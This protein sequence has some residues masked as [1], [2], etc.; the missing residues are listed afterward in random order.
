MNEKS[1]Y[2]T[3]AIDYA[4]SNPHIGHVYE[5][6]VADV[7]VR[8]HRLLGYKTRFSIGTDE[9]GEKIFK[10]AKAQGV[11][12]QEFVD[13]IVPE[14]FQALYKRLGISAD[15]FIRTTESGHKK[16]V[17]QMLERAQ[18]AG[19]IYLAEYEG[20]YSV[21]SERFVTE[22]ELVESPDGL[23]RLPGDKDPPELRREQ[24][25]FLRMEKYRPWLL[26]YIEA[27]PDFIQPVGYKNELLEMLREPVGDLSISRPVERLP[28]GIPIPWDEGHV[29]YVWYDALVNYLSQCYTDVPAGSSESLEHFWQ[30]TWHVIGKDIL[31]PHALFWPVMLK[32]AGYPL[33]ERLN[34]HGHI[35]AA[36]GQ[37]MGKSLGNALNPIALL[38]TYGVDAVRY[39]LT[40]DT[41]YGPDSAFGEEG[42][43]SRLNSDLA[44]DLGN[45]LSRVGSMVQKFRAGVVPA[46]AAYDPRE[47]AIIDNFAVLPNRVLTEVRDLRLHLGVEAVLESVRDLNKFVAESKPWD[48]AKDESKSQRLDTVLY[49]L[50]EGLRLISL[51][52]EPVIP[53]KALEIRRQLGLAVSSATG[54]G[55]SQTGANSLAWGGLQGGQKLQLGEILFPKIEAKENMT[56]ETSA[57]AVVVP[58]YISIDDFIKIELRVALVTACERI[59]KADKLLKLTVSLGNETRTVLSGIAQHYTPEEMVGKRVVLVAN[60]A[61]RAM[62]GIES[63][64]MILAGEDE[65]GRIVIVAPEKD[66]PAGS[67]VK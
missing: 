43:V 39:A 34:V 52:L 25:Y 45:L 5:K 61:P 2:L 59:P 56:E 22:K 3:T 23:K 17:Q 54:I 49:T 1:F 28:W 64:G 16:F 4:N 12:P 14:G 36:D 20:L 6:I 55:A 57:A 53:E 41:T 30:K 13:K 44:N 63:Q 50:L 40:R 19:D 15:R 31:K 24:N 47:Q 35:T 7:I 18:A 33:Y 32:S 65:T 26:E 48:L 62:R 21:G 42:L 27:N 66:L 11:A 37:K 67:K 29:V 58:N 46:P 51:L 10:A 8:Y 60:L 38:D 9:H